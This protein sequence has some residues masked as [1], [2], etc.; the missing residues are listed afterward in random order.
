MNVVPCVYPGIVLERNNDSF[1]PFV[2]LVLVQPEFSSL[3][4][5]AWKTKCALVNFNL[6]RRNNIGEAKFKALNLHVSL[7]VVAQS[8]TCATSLFSMVFYMARKKSNWNLVMTVDIIR[9][10]EIPF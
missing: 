1:V 2:N 9:L 5:D 7:S 3:N 4:A 6:L 8:Y 10:S